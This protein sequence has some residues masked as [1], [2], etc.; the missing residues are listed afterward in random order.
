MR[1]HKAPEGAAAG[2]WYLARLKPGALE[3]ARAHLARQGFEC[4]MPMQA[5]TRRRAG[6]LTE[7]KR[8]LFPGYLF[9]RAPEAAPRWQAINATR[10]VSALVSVGSDGPTPVPAAIISGL[11]AEIGRDGLLN[12]AAAFGAGERVRVISGA[13]AETLARIEA[14]GEGDRIFVIIDMMG[15]S[16]RTAL[17][18]RD[19][20]RA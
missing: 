12:P 6:R 11:R 20:E 3:T 18:A 15:R 10:G 5:V 17:T 1:G 16:V 8:P 13:F 2:V 4:F 7:A 14:L 9:V 19:L